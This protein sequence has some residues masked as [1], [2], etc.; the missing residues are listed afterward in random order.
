MQRL[1]RTLT[2]AV[3]VIAASP[4][5]AAQIRWQ[6]VV[7]REAGF[8]VSFP[9]QPAYRETTA[10]ETGL[11][12]EVYSFY[13]N[14]NLLQVTF[15]PLEPA[16]KTALE[17]NQVLSNSAKVYAGG[18]IGQEKLPDG[19][20]QLDNLLET[21]SGTLHLRTR[22]YVH[23][24]K[25]FDLSCGSYEA[26][27]I[28]ER[29]AEQFFSS[30]SFTDSLSGRRATPARKAVRDSAP[31]GGK[32]ARWYTFNAPDGDFVVEF[33][34]RP[35]Y[36]TLKVPGT[37]APMRRYHYFFGENKFMVS[38]YD[39]DV[40]G[41][42]GEITRLATLHYIADYPDWQLMRKEQ[43]PDGG[44]YV[45]M[46]GMVSGFPILTQTRVYLRGRRIYYVTS[47]TQNL[48]GPN[49]SDVDRFFSSFRFL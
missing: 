7:D 45:E 18:L 6:Q 9:G 26:D 1:T 35:D 24:G 39:T 10:E 32:P 34:G 20:R 47:H 46:R 8:T 49:K 42:P 12:F 23:R 48:S 44:Y 37:N 15:Q 29:L 5:L 40:V 25:L 31:G 11:P 22:L 14:G 21:K 17:V 43:L 19:G 2:F 3:M 13:Y 28:D 38:Y 27:G 4:A 36:L 16:P 30:F 33:P 41:D